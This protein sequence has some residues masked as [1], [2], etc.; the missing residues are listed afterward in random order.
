MAYAITRTLLGSKEGGACCLVVTV[1][2]MA[3]QEARSELSR[4]DALVTELRQ[5]LEEVRESTQ[6]RGLIYLHSIYGWYKG[7]HGWVVLH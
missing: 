4:R 5:E 3:W 2:L 7:Y 1:T 6:T